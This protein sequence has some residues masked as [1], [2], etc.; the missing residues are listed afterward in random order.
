MSYQVNSISSKLDYVGGE[1]TSGI[2]FEIKYKCHE[3]L[4]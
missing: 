1:G 3:V 4:L 2:P